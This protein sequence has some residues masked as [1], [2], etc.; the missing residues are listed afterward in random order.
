MSRIKVATAFSGGGIGIAAL[1]REAYEFVFAIEYDPRVAKLYALNY[2]EDNLLIKRI[3]DVSRDEVLVARGLEYGELDIFQASPVCKNFSVAKSNASEGGEELSQAA[4]TALI[5]EWTYP[6]YVL[7]ENV[8]AYRNSASFKLINDVLEDLYYRVEW[9]VINC[10]DMGVPQTRKRLILVASRDDMPNYVWPEPT[11]KEG[12]E[13]EGLWGEGRK[14]WVGWLEAVEDI[15]DTFPAAKFADWQLKRL[16]QHPVYTSLHVNDFKA[17]MVES[18]NAHQQYG[19]GAREE[20][21]PAYTVTAYDRPAHIP[22]ALLSPINGANSLGFTDEEPAQTIT[23]AHTAAKYRAF[24]IPGD[25]T[26]NDTVR[27]DDEP[28]VTVRARSIGQCPARAYLVDGQ[29]NGKGAPITVRDEEEPSHTILASATRKPFKAWLEEG[30][31]VQ[32][33]PRAL[34][35]FQSV[36]D[37]YQLSG[38][39][40]VD[41]I[42]IGNGI[43]SL[44]IKIFFE[45]M[46]GVRQANREEAAA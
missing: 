23:A 13:P 46:S 6:K 5:I 33:T 19:N 16:E 45:A 11:H 44:V 28:F 35:R 14:P 8:S 7:I 10:A 26:S 17:L 20:G 22:K 31:V 36:P 21:K 18:K 1:D 42:A 27:E 2:G 3:Q 32:L 29:G 15:I 24:I 30:R 12:G 25:N 41:A 34:A 37:T 39:N 43:P 40:A 9:R 4:A 38:Q